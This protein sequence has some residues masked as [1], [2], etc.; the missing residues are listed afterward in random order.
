MLL[1]SYYLNRLDIILEV[2][3]TKPEV[4]I[5]DWKAHPGGKWFSI[6]NFHFTVIVNALMFYLDVRFLRTRNKSK[7]QKGQLRTGV[8]KSVLNSITD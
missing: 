8:G 5:I 6:F 1:S 4:R 2:L 7:T 3:F